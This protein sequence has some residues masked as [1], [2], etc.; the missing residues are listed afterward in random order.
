MLGNVIMLNIL[1]AIFNFRYEQVQSSSKK[2]SAYMRYL[3]TL[4]YYS[5]T[6]LPPP[7]VILKRDQ[8]LKISKDTNVKYMLN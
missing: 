2:I 5:K 4:E 1:I 8:K 7:F 6:S 3:L